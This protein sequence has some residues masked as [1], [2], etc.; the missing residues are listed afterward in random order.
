[1]IGIL[2]D[3]QEDLGLS[4]KHLGI[5]SCFLDPENNMIKEEETPNPSNLNAEVLEFTKEGNIV[6]KRLPS[7]VPKRD[8]IWEFFVNPDEGIPLESKIIT[9]MMQY[10]L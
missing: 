10:F 3:A 9:E 7:N 5:L 4:E 2:K 1:M 8:P 6:P